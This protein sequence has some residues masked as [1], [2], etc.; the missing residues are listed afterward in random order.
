[1]SNASFQEN[2]PGWQFEL[3]KQKL[4]E[5]WELKI[6]EIEID[7]PDLSIFDSPLIRLGIKFILWSLITIILVWLTWQLWLVLRPVINNWRRQQQQLKRSQ[8]QFSSQIQLSPQEWL[9][10][11]RQHYQEQN[12]RQGIFC[13]YQGI[14]QY[15]SDREMIN[16]LSSRTDGEYLKLIQQLN[17]K[18][19]LSYKLLFSTHEKLCFSDLFPSASLFNECEQAYQLITNKDNQQI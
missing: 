7:S 13:L 5:W 14:L 18:Q 1:M 17:L 3:G 15:L 6:S 8:I 10:R 12:Y 9:A 19:L 16:S 2:S 11:G 4:Q